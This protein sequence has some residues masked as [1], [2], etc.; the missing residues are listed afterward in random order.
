MNWE[1]LV[2]SS[3]EKA[4]WA[5]RAEGIRERLVSMSVGV[6]VVHWEKWESS[7]EPSELSEGAVCFQ[8]VGQA[9]QGPRGDK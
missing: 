3:W 7:V 5:V 9:G 8:R 4:D 6:R 2:S 1:Q